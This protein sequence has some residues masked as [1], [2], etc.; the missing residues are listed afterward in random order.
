MKATDT[1]AHTHS[2][3][4]D[5]CFMP[6]PIHVDEYS[7]HRANQRPRSFTVDEQVF[8]IEAVLDQWYQPSG[9]YFKV[10]TNKTDRA[11]VGGKPDKWDCLHR[12]SV[13]GL[14]TCSRPS[15]K[16]LAYRALRFSPHRWKNLEN[17]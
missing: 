4:C 12:R 13:Q 16:S 3:E 2:R 10:R 8:N 9:T 15:S 7:G 11:G 5:N 17:S 14:N 1:A 6:F